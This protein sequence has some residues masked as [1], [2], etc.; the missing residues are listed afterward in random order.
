[1]ITQQPFPGVTNGAKAIWNWA[2]GGRINVSEAWSLH[3]GFFSDYSPTTASGQNLFRSVNMYGATVGARVKG[4]HFS[5]SVGFGFDWGSSQNFAFGDPASG[6]VIS[7]QLNVR[8]L[9][10]LYALTYTF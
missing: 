6:A 2:V 10:L 4:E 1:V 9:S 7:T 3:A 5:G 8:S